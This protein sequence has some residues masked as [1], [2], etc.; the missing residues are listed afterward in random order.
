MTTVPVTAHGVVNIGQNSKK[1]SAEY[2]RGWS[3]IRTDRAQAFARFL[4]GYPVVSTGLAVS[5]T[6]TGLQVA[7]ATGEGFDGNGLPIYLPASIPST[8]VPLGQSAEGTA[9]QVTLA[10]AHASL[11]RIDLVYLRASTLLTDYDMVWTSVNGVTAQALLPKTLLDYFTIGVVQGTPNASPVAPSPALT[12]DLVLAQVTVPAAATT[13]NS[14][15][16]T[17]VR[18]MIASAL[19]QV[20]FPKRITAGSSYTAALGE[21]VVL[22]LA[23]PVAFA[24]TLPPGPTKGDTVQFKDSTGALAQ[25][26]VTITPSSGTIDGYTSILLTRPGAELAFTYDGT[27]WILK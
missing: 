23:T 10:A 27:Q 13:L 24:L 22:A 3:M 21:L 19:P 18:F 12:T 6:G 17:D 4:R 15:N 7:V 14:G 8:L 26:P 25:Y 2:T 11:P 5:A 9:P 20:V 16:I 1:D